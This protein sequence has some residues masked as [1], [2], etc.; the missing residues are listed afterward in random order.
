MSVVTHAPTFT[1][2]SH[3]C[4]QITADTAGQSVTLNGWVSVSRDLGGLVFIELRDRSGLLQL[5]SDPNKNPDVHKLLASLKSEDVITASGVISARPTETINAKH[6]TGTLEL[7]PTQVEILNRAKTPPFPLDEQAQSVDENVRLKYRYL[8][9]RR[10]SMFN[11][12][13]LRHDMVLALRNHLNAK[14]FLEVETPILIKTTPEGAR[15]YLVPSRVHP[16]HAF[17]L[18]QSP[19]L[20]KQLLMVSGIE[21]Y[22]QV[23]RCF[24]DED[25]RADR[26]PEF[27]QIDMELS[28]VTQDDILALVEDLLVDVFAVANVAITAPFQRMTWETA[29]NQ[30]GSDKPDLR[31]DLPFTDLTSVF[32]DSGFSAFKGVVTDGGVVKAL[33]VPG[34]ASYS[35]KEL[36]ELQAMAK[37]FGAKGL[38]YILYAEDGPKSPILK[39]MSESEQTAITEK[40]GAKTGDAVFF[41]ADKLLPACNTLGRFR[42]WF[43]EKHQLINPNQHSILW[44]TDFP[45]FE[46]T[47]TG[48]LTP[49]HHPFTAPHPDDIGLLDTQAEKARSLG[50]DVVYNG[51]EIGGGSVRIH[52]RDLQAKI[53]NL[54]GLTPEETQQKFGFLLEAFEYGTPPHGGLALGLDRMVALLAGASSIREV[55]A[56]PKTNQAMCPMT[57]APGEPDEAQLKD[58]HMR[59]ALPPV[60]PPKASTVA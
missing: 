40:T 27:T 52:Q 12:L 23:A 8:D 49:N 51:T 6:P 38:A 13:K 60:A 47:E 31:F 53:F 56:F 2:R 58:L 37:Q 57:D 55:I 35:R 43:A 18:P 48:G 24:R 32:A 28:F 4:N 19:Q 5:V 1:Q 21:R 16:G 34:A 22:Y 41:M 46:R 39:F 15:D 10:P 45:M 54:L 26:Q 29:M 59:W 30:Y 44:V 14:G 11:N 7:Y 17:A 3:F 9:L 42:L 33:R 20:F 50:Y 36:D 25:L